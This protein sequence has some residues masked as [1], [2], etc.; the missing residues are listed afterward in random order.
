MVQFKD[1]SIK[2]Q[3]GVPDMRI[4]IT[5]AL[6]YPKRIETAWPRVK[7]EKLSNLTFIKPDFELLEGPRL[8]HHAIKKG[9]KAPSNLRK[10]NDESV[11]KFLN[12]E[13]SFL[14]IYSSI[15]AEI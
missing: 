3:M 6:S 14:E 8:A 15:R 1:G 12:K 9:G 4:P 13:I 2:A 7:F 11:K 5:Y 10:A